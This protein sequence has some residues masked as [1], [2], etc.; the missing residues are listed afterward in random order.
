MENA[1]KKTAA[2]LLYEKQLLFKAAAQAAVVF[3]GFML[4]SVSFDGGI[5]PFG[6]AF[7]GGAADEYLLSACVGTAFGALV[8]CEQ[9]QALKY[10]GAAVLIFFLRTAAS[11]RIKDGLKL[12]FYTA[13]TFVC[14]AVCALVVSLAESPDAAALILELCNAVIAGSCAFF[15]CRMF[16]LLTAGKA[17]LGVR[18]GDSAAFML[19]GSLLLLS[20]NRFNIGG[21]SPARVLTYLCIMLISYCG[22]ENSGTMAG[23]CAGTVFGLSD[24][25]GH[26]LFALPLGGLV[27]GLCSDYGKAAVS[28]GFAVSYMLALIMK[29]DA[30]CA[31]LCAAECA[32]AALVFALLP[33]KLIL[34]FDGILMPFSKAGTEDEARRALNMRVEKSA[35]AVRDV[36]C[37]VE[38]VCRMLARTDRPDV[39]AIPGEVKDDVCAD[40]T[41]RDFCWQ[42]S[43][44]M[45]RRAFN[46]CLKILGDSGRL[47][48]EA[49][50]ERLGIV[51]REKNAVCD[52]FNRLMCEYNAR[53]TVRG[54]IFEAKAL[55][56][57]QFRCAADIMED[58]AARA[59]SS[60]TPDARFTAI[61]GTVFEEFGFGLSSLSV[62][63]VKSDRCVIEAVCSRLPEK[64]DFNA[65]LQRLADKT[66]T[67][68]MPPVTENRKN[69]TAMLTL[70]EKT[71]L[72]VQHYKLSRTG[73]GE[74]LCGDCCE[75]FADGR[76]NFFCVL[77]D[78]MGTG[79][80]AALDSVMTCSLFSKLMKAGFSVEAAFSAVNSALAVKSAD[81][82]LAT[83]DILRLDL[84]TGDAV[85]YKAGGAYSV[86]YE[87]GRAKFTEQ[88]SMPL[89]I[90]RETRFEHT[91]FS[92]KK[93]DAVLMISDGAQSAGKTFFRSIFSSYPNADPESVCRAVV[94]TAANATP[95][96]KIDDMT[97][98]CVKIV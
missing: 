50:P 20:L 16:T 3:A 19:W 62:Y 83:L 38:T 29:G 71:V 94:D 21:F 70:C 46:D 25:T 52:S 33:K 78:G 85:I 37:S 47:T 42:R 96:G 14:S 89:G 11:K 98:V 23:V 77:S 86:I 66:G 95:S 13:L 8:F 6:T 30:D 24:G 49:L 73:D 27:G 41:K 55:A 57:A 43:G 36:A 65:V 79:S 68:F 39:H 44:E 72:G 90:L 92:L 45:T 26:L 40:C 56:A 80:R 18:T 2:R 4:S 9:G 82:S 59:V 32:G 69:G 12:R 67:D 97:A 10:V 81:E 75:T 5:Y 7:A 35:Q 34:R 91:G 22:R 48:P 15:A 74:K 84:Y 87:N 1:K 53:L 58:A 63:G 60:E 76:G 88:A 31:L 64:P 17:T 61:T 51:C 54:E 93:G 28:A